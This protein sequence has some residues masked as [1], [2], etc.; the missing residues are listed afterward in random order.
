MKKILLGLL[1][2]TLL[3]P[4]TANAQKAPSLRE[5][6]ESLNRVT[7][8]VQYHD[9]R[10]K[11]QA[12]NTEIAP[13][14][15]YN[16][17]ERLHIAYNS[18]ERRYN[19]FLTIVKSDLS[20]AKAIKKMMRD[21]KGFAEGYADEYKKVIDTYERD[22]VPVYEDV[23]N[24]KGKFITPTLIAVGI[25]LVSQVVDWIVK[26][27][28][29]RDEQ[30]NIILGIVNKYFYDELRMKSWTELGLKPA[31]NI[32]TSTAGTSGAATNIPVPPSVQDP[33][34]VPVP[35]FK[36]LVGYIEFVSTAKMGDEPK[37]MNFAVKKGKDIDVGYLEAQPTNTTSPVQVGT[38][39]VPVQFYNS[40]E[41]FAS[42]SGFQLRVNN[43]AGMYVFALNSN[44]KV[45]TLYP[46]KNVAIPDCS[47]AKKTGMKDIDVGDLAP[48]PTVGQDIDGNSILPQ[49]D[50]TVQPPKPRYFTING[51]QTTPENFCV[52]L[53]KSELN[54]ADIAARIEAETGTLPERLARIF[55]TQAISP[56]DA[57][58]AMQDNKLTF[59]AR[60]AK[61]SV[62]PI[63]FF[64][65]RK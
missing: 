36:D 55:G 52:L 34:Q 20:D 15:S 43:K 13:K 40:I 26:R 10:D 22:Y 31:A 19:D 56:T 30:V 28:E 25:E 27:Q 60:G 41:S 63:V 6:C 8:F 21:P 49:M 32:P 65:Q 38:A 46:Y 44:Q 59:D 53:T 2:L 45:T 9:F 50:C 33:V 39:T 5:I 17:H 18:V 7:L 64:I 48:T 42:G 23:K 54:S 4:M 16:E 62:I 35:V 37:S 47:A 29:L 3:L 1:T 51:S 61:N 57:N 24:K 14:L 12:M 11:F 58:L